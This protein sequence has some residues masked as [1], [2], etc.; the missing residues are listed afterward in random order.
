M[1][2]LSAWVI[3]FWICALFVRL[4]RSFVN[5]TSE[6]QP[7]QIR[8]LHHDSSFGSYVIMPMDS[9]SWYVI[10]GLAFQFGN[11]AVH[12][13]TW[14][15]VPITIL[16][17]QQKEWWYRS[18]SWRHKFRFLG[19]HINEG[20][21]LIEK[22]SGG[23]F[24][25]ICCYGKGALVD[26]KWVSQNFVLVLPLFDRS[27]RYWGRWLTRNEIGCKFYSCIAV[28]TWDYVWIRLE[29]FF[30]LFFYV[31]SF[32]NALQ[33]YIGYRLDSSSVHASTWKMYTGSG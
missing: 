11:W 10:L 27:L 21:W 28:F 2:L 14:V 18:Y 30:Y 8:Q 32:I 12:P 1:H 13:I 23:E 9:L 7:K 4:N 20:R 22:V 15:I 25:F 24:H 29:L 16:F 31:L 17:D 19:C 5:V 26:K 3:G 6:I 33:K